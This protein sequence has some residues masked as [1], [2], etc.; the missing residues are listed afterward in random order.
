MFALFS[1]RLE[2]RSRRRN[3]D[4]RSGWHH[5]QTHFYALSVRRHIRSVC[6]VCLPLFWCINIFH[7]FIYS[8][9]LWRLYALLIRPLARLSASAKMFAVSSLSFLNAYWAGVSPFSLSFSGSVPF[10]RRNGIIWWQFH[11]VAECWTVSG[12]LRALPW[13]L[14]P[15]LCTSLISQ[16]WSRNSSIAVFPSSSSL[17]IAYFQGIPLVGSAPR[18]SKSLMV[19][20]DHSSAAWLIERQARDPPAPA[21]GSAPWSRSHRTAT[22]W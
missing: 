20:T 6:L 15:L 17:M 16:P 9:C 14:M 10:S 21:Y 3:R 19:S 8:N 11:Q 12:S 2:K 4:P 18:L 13:W 5:F 1:A 7:M 22:S